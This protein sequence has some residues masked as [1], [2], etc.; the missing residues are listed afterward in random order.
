MA[1]N[2]KKKKYD[3]E[4][5]S[6]AVDAYWQ[7]KSEV[8]AYDDRYKNSIDGTLNRIQNSK[9]EYDA[10]KDVNAQRRIGALRQS[11][12]QGMTDTLGKATSLTGGYN[13][14]HAQTAAQQV[15]DQTM[16]Q[17]DEILAAAR[18]QAY[19][20]YRDKLADERASLS[21]LMAVSE[22]DYGRWSD[23]ASRADA[24]ANNY[25]SIAQ[26]LA[27]RE[28]QKER[29]GV[30]DS[31]WRENFNYQKER[32]AVAD[33][34]W[35][36]SFDYQKESDAADRRAAAQKSSSG[37][38]SGAE[39]EPASTTDMKYYTEKALGVNVGPELYEFINGVYV[40]GL[41]SEQ[42]AYQILK[43]CG[44]NDPAAFIEREG[45]I[46][47]ATTPYDIIRPKYGQFY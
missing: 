24:E 8:G 11:A 33:S 41:I 2:D 16:S 34:Q 10:G 42:Q 40:D 35:Q 18:D 3:L 28:Y 20:E 6:D 47:T 46:G 27:A 12:K 32:D 21:D 4:T 29:D 1:T 36:Q 17:A 43:D 23:A 39:Y 25:L 5:S 38:T 37:D 31:Q 7:K 30:A 13:N 19:G 26:D 44:V 9:F 14:S 22:R 45:Y 15:Y